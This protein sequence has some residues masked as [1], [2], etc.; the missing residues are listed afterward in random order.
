[1]DLVIRNGTVVDGSG[2]SARVADVGIVGERVVAVEPALAG[3]GHREIEADGRVV[4]PGFVD[5]HTHLDA[6]LAW[7][8]IGTSSCWHGVTSVVMGNCGVTFAPCRPEDRPYLAELMES[9]ED[10]PRDAILG[11][12]PWDWVTYGEYLGSMG[13]LPKGPNVGGLVGHC[14]V[15][16]HAM[17][18]RSLDDTPATEDDITAM[19]ELVDEAM[20]AG[21][22]GFSTSRTLLHTV[23]DGRPVPGTWA[24]PDELFAFADVLG[25]HHRGTFET[26]SRLG[27]RDG[28]DLAGTRAE[29][30]WMGEVSRRSGRPVTFGLVQSDRR[31]EL[32]RQIVGFAK[33]QNALGGC[34]RPQTTARGVGVLFGLQSRTPFDRSPAWQALHGLSLQEQLLV[35]R[36]AARRS[37][38]IA[39]A[40]EHPPRLDLDLLFVL[41]PGPARYDCPPDTSLAAHAEQRGVSPAAAFIELALETDGTL[42]CNFPFLNQ[43]LGAVEEM[44]DDPLVTLGLADAGAH[45]GQ[46]MDA[47]QPTFLLT[48]LVRERGRWGLEEAVRRLTSDTA[49][50]F[51]IADRGVL[52]PGAFA[53]VNVIDLEALTLHQPEF[54]HDF[55][56]GAGRYV[57][58]SSGYDY[59]LVN[60]EV[61][62]DHG[63]HAGALPGH[64]LRSTD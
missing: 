54:V 33:E 51:G 37:Q 23:P 11:G 39:E 44:L 57:Q 36:D 50:L 30:A 49:Q 4:T 26:A 61:F 13:R 18:E 9:V 14:A 5:I 20:D 31:P 12:L 47:S 27:E 34:V 38:L 59:T 58:G 56:G 60:G 17:G 29:L 3:R 25:R 62:M 2:A 63:E 16:Q 6:Q 55:P 21:A 19:A 15:R 53:D 52:L 22:L 35:L 43:R 40:E 8:P 48:Y 24:T 45:V 10:I 41:P 32:F 64:L 28:E 1:M 46:I 7:D 42:V